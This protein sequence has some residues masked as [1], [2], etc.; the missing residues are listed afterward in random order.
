[1][2]FEKVQ[3]IEKEKKI[4]I[5]LHRSFCEMTKKSSQEFKAYLKSNCPR[6]YWL[7]YVEYA[8]IGTEWKIEDFFRINMVEEVIHRIKNNYQD[9]ELE[10]CEWMFGGKDKEVF[11]EECNR[12]TLKQLYYLLKKDNSGEYYALLGQRQRL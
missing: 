11:D 3:N 8:D 2:Q 9:L 10:E 6:F 5:F 7:L 12:Q 4:L 1:M